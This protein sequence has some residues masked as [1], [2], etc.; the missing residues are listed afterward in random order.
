MPTAT[1]SHRYE[2]LVFD[3][4]GTLIDSAPDI[5]AALNLVLERNRWPT[6]SVETVERFIGFGARRLVHDLFVSLDLPSDDAT[7]DTALEEYLEVK[8]VLGY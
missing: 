4:D 3:L 1:R 8:A 2:A 7:I 5:A 6:Q